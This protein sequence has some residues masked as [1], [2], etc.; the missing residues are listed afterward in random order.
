MVG[1]WVPAL[2]CPLLLLGVPEE[3]LKKLK[4]TICLSM[5]ELCDIFSQLWI[6]AKNVFV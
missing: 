3:S 2:Y 4:V 1:V 6:T 5:S